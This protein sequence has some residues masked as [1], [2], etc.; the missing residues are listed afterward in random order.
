MKIIGLA[1]I[2]SALFLSACASTP[3]EQESS[4][5]SEATSSMH[6]YRCESGE[7]ITA[8]YPSTDSATVQYKGNTYDMQVAVS[9][10]GA[11]Y[12]GAQLEWWTKGS[13]TGSEGTLF[14]HNADGTSG[15]IV[16]TCKE[17]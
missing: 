15:D 8:T 10:S 3:K 7:A 11:R 5:A 13:G 9:G 17:S 2:S 4:S 6:S 12:V 16:E 1:A 14:H